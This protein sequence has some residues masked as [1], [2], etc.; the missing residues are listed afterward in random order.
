MGPHGNDDDRVGVKHESA[1]SEEGTAL[2]SGQNRVLEM[3]AEGAPLGDTLTALLGVIEEN[4]PE[5]LCSILLLDPD[6]VHLRHGAAPSLP[7]DYMKSIDGSAIGPS[8]GSCGTAAFRR[9]A[10]FVES[11]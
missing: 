7:P 9:E 4:A 11:I 8:A 3:V 1:S 2:L 10:V 5:M 6:G